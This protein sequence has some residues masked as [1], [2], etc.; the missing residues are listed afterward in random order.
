[1]TKIHNSATCTAGFNS[2]P[3]DM[4]Q[5]AREVE[6]NRSKLPS[7]PLT[8]EKGNVG[9]LVPEA[10]NALS[11]DSGAGTSHLIT[12]SKLRAVL[13]DVVDSGWQC[14]HACDIKH[15]WH[16]DPYAEDDT[17]TEHRTRFVDTVMERAFHK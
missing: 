8:T 13:F 3:C 10:E 12:R 15:P 17:E 14:G 4:C 5:F 9:F 11:G 2:R 1:M 16:F 6:E 7:E